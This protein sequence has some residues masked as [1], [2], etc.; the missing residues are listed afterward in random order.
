MIRIPRLP[1]DEFFMLHAHLAATRS[2]CDRGP[3]LLLDPGRKGVGAVLVRENRI[4]AGGYNGSPPGE[5]HCGEFVC[6]ECE[7]EF[8]AAEIRSEWNA[9]PPRRVFFETIV[10]SDSSR[11]ATIDG[12]RGAGPQ[13]VSCGECG[14]D[15]EG[16]HL[17]VDGH[18]VRTL[19]AEEN[20]L[21]Q[22]ALDGVSP[23]GT[24][25]F[26]SASPCY[27]CAKR[28]V[29]VGV[30]RVCFAAAYGSRYGLSEDAVGLLRRAGIEIE[31]VD[32]S[33]VVRDGR[34]ARPTFT[35]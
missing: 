2:T 15:L 34:W 16:G 30:V 8:S 25:V 32:V 26:T 14:A 6:S 11:G 10:G 19:H 21:L 13:S 4:V 9:L 27:D 18:C 17:L 29:R 22:C 5:P 35:F 1:W 20:A 12:I 24:T 33:R 23:R 28:L 7:A 3:G 31:H